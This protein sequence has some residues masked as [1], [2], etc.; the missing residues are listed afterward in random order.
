VIDKAIQEYDE[1]HAD[2]LTI[3]SDLPEQVRERITDS[4]LSW[5]EG[6]WQIIR[7]ERDT[8]DEQCP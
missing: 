4:S 6:L 3:P 8:N 5:N 1:Q 7:E 2:T